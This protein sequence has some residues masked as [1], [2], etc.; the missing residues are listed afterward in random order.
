MI[1]FKN[2]RVGTYTYLYAARNLLRLSGLV[3]KISPNSKFA[4]RL[5]VTWKRYTNESLRYMKLW[6][7]KLQEKEES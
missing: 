1:K 4:R 5:E 2:P 3:R 6:L 7:D